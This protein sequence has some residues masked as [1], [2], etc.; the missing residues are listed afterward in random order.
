MVVSRLFDA[1]NVEMGIGIEGESCYELRRL[2]T[3]DDIGSDLV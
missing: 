3:D 1:E 2:E